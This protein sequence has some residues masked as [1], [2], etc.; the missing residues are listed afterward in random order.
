MFVKCIFDGSLL[1]LDNRF[2]RY[3][4]FDCIESGVM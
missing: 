2:I 4:K 1:N 3:L